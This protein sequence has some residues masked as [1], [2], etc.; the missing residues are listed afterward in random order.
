[1]NVDNPKYYYVAKTPTGEFIGVYTR[2]ELVE[3]RLAGEIHAEHVATES[4]G[5]SYHQ[6]IKTWG[7]NAKWKTVAQ[8]LATDTAAPAPTTDAPRIPEQL[9]KAYAS[10]GQMP[11][12]LVN[13]GGGSV[14]GF[15]KIGTGILAGL[16]SMSGSSSGSSVDSGRTMGGAV[17]AMMFIGTG[18]SDIL[19]A[20]ATPTQRSKGS[21]KE[22][23]SE[24]YRLLI[25]DGLVAF[26]PYVP[27]TTTEQ[28]ASGEEFEA[29]KQRWTRA[30]GGLEPGSRQIDGAIQVIEGERIDEIVAVVLVILKLK[31][32]PLLQFQNICLRKSE[33]WYLTSME[34]VAGS[35]EDIGQLTN[36]LRST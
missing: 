10:L 21:L 7:V 15:F 23:C 2:H 25:N 3:Q 24:F 35:K 8:L 17:V 19:A 27:P 34:P 11:T 31:D 28:Y 9:A 6:F 4:T 16:A 1:M 14:V 5:D 18:I 12:Q 20:F 32:G 30:C 36:A 13:Q 29:L 33:Y 26:A 22:A